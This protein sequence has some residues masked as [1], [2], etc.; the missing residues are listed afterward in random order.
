MTSGLLIIGMFVFNAD[1]LTYGSKYREELEY[2]NE[3]LAAKVTE[4][5]LE[6]TL[7]SEELQDRS[8]RELEEF[9]FVASHDF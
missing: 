9:A 2:Q 7:Y 4:R 5:T 6:L 8:N 3:T 1:Q